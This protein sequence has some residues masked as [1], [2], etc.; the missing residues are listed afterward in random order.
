MDLGPVQPVSI[1]LDLESSALLV[2]EESSTV[3]PLDLVS[4]VLGEP[5]HVGKGD[6][7]RNV[8]GLVTNGER[9][10]WQSDACGGATVG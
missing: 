7:Q 1:A 3:R 2:G 9:I 10:Y 8:R 6:G 4:L 5:I